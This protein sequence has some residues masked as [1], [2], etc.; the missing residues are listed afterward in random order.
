MHH[1]AV[2][3]IGET[4]PDAA[5]LPRLERRSLLASNDLASATFWHCYL[6]CGLIGSISKVRSAMDSANAQ[7]PVDNSVESLCG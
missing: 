4:S 5:L 3:R 1:S 6:Y 2:A 7:R